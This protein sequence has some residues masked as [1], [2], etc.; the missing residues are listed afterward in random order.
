MIYN[1]IYNNDKSM[2]KWENCQ[3]KI[4]TSSESEQPKQIF[5]HQTV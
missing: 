2:A 1:N 4:T 5:K 3:H